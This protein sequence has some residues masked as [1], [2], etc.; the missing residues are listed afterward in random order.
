LIF[1]GLSGGFFVAAVDAT[2]KRRKA[3][4]KHEKEAR[5]ADDHHDIASS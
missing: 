3:K 2:V 4:N 5:N 1:T